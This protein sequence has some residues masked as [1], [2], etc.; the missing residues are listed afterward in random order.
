M[1][2]DWEELFTKFDETNQTIGALWFEKNFLTE[3]TKKLEAELF[4]VRAQLE[5]TSNA[6]LDEMLSF[7]KSASDKTRLG[8]NSQYRLILP[9]LVKMC[10]SYLLMIIFL[11]MLTLKL[12]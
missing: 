9:C 3:R 11:R 4:Q 12:K 1:E 6:K 2:L 8:M 5:R 7:R 10:L